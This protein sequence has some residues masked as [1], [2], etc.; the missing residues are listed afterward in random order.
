[1]IGRPE[2]EAAAARVAP[3][4]RRTPVIELDPTTLGTPA[5]IVLKLECLQH[6]GSFKP[7]GAFNRILSAAVPAAGVIAASG[8]NHGLAVAYAARKLGHRAEIFVPS[9][10]APVKIAGL[11]ALDAQVEIVGANYAEAFAASVQRQQE[12]GALVV[13]A[14]DQAE[15]LAGQGTTARELEEQAPHLD[16]VLVAVGGGGFIGG[17]A[18]WYAGRTRL[19]GVEPETSCALHAALAAGAPVDVEVSGIAADSL[20]ARRVGAL[21]FPLARDHVERVVLVSDGEIRAAQTALWRQLRIMA[22]PGG[23]AAFASLLAGRYRPAP[24]EKVG[25]LVCGANGDPGAIAAG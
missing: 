13:H 19:I 17:I 7:R 23:A 20:G 4:V 12:T 14:Y 6:T 24:G 16:T 22:E 11:R 18:G 9:I 25:V 2:I 3:H 21:M 5:P 15:V 10:A 1:M 8:G